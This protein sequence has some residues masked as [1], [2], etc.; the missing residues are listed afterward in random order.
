MFIWNDKELLLMALIPFLVG[1]D[2]NLQPLD[3]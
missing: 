1:L 3:K 2:I